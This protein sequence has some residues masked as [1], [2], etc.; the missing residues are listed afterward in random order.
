MPAGECT[1][2]LAELGKK[3]YGFLDRSR[4]VI[5]KSGWYHM[6]FPFRRCFSCQQQATLAIFRR[7]AQDLF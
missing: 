4:S 5:R 6:Y 2:L 3:A 7:F 1:P